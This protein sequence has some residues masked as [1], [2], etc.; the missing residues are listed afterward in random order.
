MSKLLN[1]TLHYKGKKLDQVRY[2]RDFRTSSLS[3]RIN[4]SSGK[5]WMSHFQKSTCLSLKKV[6]SFTCSCLLVRKK[7]KLC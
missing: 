2:G 5:S 1:L 6:I 4:T 7:S 3:V